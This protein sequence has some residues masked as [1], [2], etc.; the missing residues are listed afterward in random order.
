MSFYG[1]NALVGK[2]SAHKVE[3]LAGQSQR[4]G[5]VHGQAAYDV[6]AGSP[7][8][9]VAHPSGVNVVTADANDAAT[10]LL[11]GH[12]PT[13]PA[14]FTDLALADVADSLTL[15][16]E[17]YAVVLEGTATVDG[18]ALDASASL[19]MVEPSKVLTGSFKVLTFK[20]SQ[21]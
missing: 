5:G 20:Y 8:E 1:K 21:P 11:V 15:D 13:T 3:V 10:L 19:P 18:T 17:T 4:F 12:N 7:I 14:V 16:A 9:V 6:V 2:F